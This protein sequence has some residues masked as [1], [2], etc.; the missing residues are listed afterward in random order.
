MPSSQQVKTQETSETENHS[1]QSVQRKPQEPNKGD[2]PASQ[3]D[4]GA[5]LEDK[6]SKA[7]ADLESWWKEEAVSR[8]KET[9]RLRKTQRLLS[10]LGS[11]TKAL[12]CL[13]GK[14]KR[15]VGQWRRLAKVA[16]VIKRSD[17][18]MKGP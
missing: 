4:I 7:I 11:H 12:A 2:Q 16:Q 9:E 1:G 6:I 18:M 3:E 8:W 17:K 10:I 15:C 13:R 5:L 14:K